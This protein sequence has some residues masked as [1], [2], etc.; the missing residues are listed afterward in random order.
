M[1]KYVNKSQGYGCL[2]MILACIPPPPSYV[3]QEL[4]ER[5]RKAMAETCTLEE[6]RNELARVD[7]VIASDVAAI[8]EKI[9]VAV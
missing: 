4:N 2:L 5:Y 3:M 8:R 9:D 7:H 6:V 1:P